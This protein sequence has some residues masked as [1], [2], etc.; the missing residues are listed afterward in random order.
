MLSPF[1][2]QLC[3]TL[4]TDHD[5]SGFEF[6]IYSNGDNKSLGFS[7][8]YAEEIPMKS[9]GS[10]VDGSPRPTCVFEPFAPNPVQSF[11]LDIEGKP[12]KSYVLCILPWKADS[13]SFLLGV[14]R[15]LVRK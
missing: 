1:P 10:V 5:L 4:C 8:F 12:L 7:A 2:S 3:P 14:Q 15:R 11:T 9:A 6:C 13:L